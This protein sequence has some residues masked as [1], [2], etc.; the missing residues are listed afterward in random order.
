MRALRFLKTNNSLYEDVQL[1][2]PKGWQSENGRFYDSP[3]LIET[4]DL[5]EE[6]TR[7]LDQGEDVLDHTNHS[8]HESSGTASDLLLLPTFDGSSTTDILQDALNDAN[9][10][11]D[12]DDYARTNQFLDPITK[13]ID[14]DK[15]MRCVVER[16]GEVEFTDASKNDYFI[17]L[18]FPYY[19]PYG[20]GGPGDQMIQAGSL[21]RT[22]RIT[23]FAEIALTSGRHYRR[24]QNDFKFISL[25]YYTSI[26]KRMAGEFLNALIMSSQSP[27]TLCLPSRCCICR[28]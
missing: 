10:D 18:C 13:R 19:F 21:S 22:A 5:T 1:A 26:R 9:N 27:I 8:T 12:S 25:C 14:V 11:N 15:L 23:K 28:A 4:I 20:R 7:V 3:R 16:G 17:E 2:W 6:E 24:L